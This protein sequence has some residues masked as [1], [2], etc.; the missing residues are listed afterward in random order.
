MLGLNQGAAVHKALQHAKNVEQ[1]SHLFMSR[2]SGGKR[3]GGLSVHHSKGVELI[4]DAVSLLWRLL[5]CK[6]PNGR[7]WGSQHFLCLLKVVVQQ[8]AQEGDALSIKCKAE[9]Q[10]RVITS[11]LRFEE[12]GI[13]LCVGSCFAVITR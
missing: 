12:Q 9:P 6:A 2:S 10:A 7:Q 5:F 4:E 1:S 13:V 8:P 11:L 3:R